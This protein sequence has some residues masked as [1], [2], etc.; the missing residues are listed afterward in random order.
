VRIV[1]LVKAVPDLDSMEFDPETKTARRSGSELFLNPFDARAALVAPTLAR[2]GD[3]TVIVSMGPP[4]ARGPLVEAMAMGSERGILISDPALIGSDSGVTAR[5]LAAALKP[6]APDL[7]LTGRWSTDSSTGQLPFQVAELLGAAAADAARSIERRGDGELEVLG[8]T[9]E[10]WAR[11]RLTTPAVVTVGEKIVKMRSPSP[12]AR[13][14]AERRNPA[15]VRIGELGF[16]PEEVGRAGSPTSVRSLRDEEPS[17]AG[18]LLSS[19]PLSDRVRE[20]GEL[21]RRLRD[22]PRSPPAPVRRLAERA[23]AAGE[24]LVFVS[25]ADGGM[26]ADT[27]PLLSEVLRLPPPLH[28]SALG[29]GPLSADDRLGLARAGAARTYW[30]DLEPGWRSPESVTPIVSEVLRLR[31][32]AVGV[33]FVNRGWGRE[34]A[35][36]VSGRTGFGLTGDAVALG[37][38]ASVG[39]T[40]SKPSFGGGLVAEVV[41]RTRTALATVRPGVFASAQ[42]DSGPGPAEVV[43]IRVPIRP[44][45]VRQIERGIERDVRFG[46]LRSARVVVVVG[47]GV[48]GPDGVREVAETVRPLRAAIAATRKV[49]DAGW[50][51][52]QLQVGLTGATVA[53]DLYVA[54]GVSGKANHMVGAKRARVSVGINSD[55]AAPL[56]ARVDVGLVGDWREVLAPLV[57][58]LGEKPV[59][60]D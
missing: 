38:D 5:V 25:P 59:L 52:P 39:L 28:P 48:G 53:P 37:W 29:F 51:P 15:V 33:L 26:D 3:S 6:L 17:R 8:E 7:I 16:R 32:E 19:G 54:V 43:P 41:S 55:P 60:P 27:L 30:C 31:P 58:A 45:H 18:R 13:A 34:L 40:F 21:V 36:R 47:L 22:R 4:E 1:T 10:G 2:T 14:E 35:G 20:A 12:E 9:E 57:E 46:D 11:Y 23:S 42:R 24:V 49:V 56:F 44:S 50:A